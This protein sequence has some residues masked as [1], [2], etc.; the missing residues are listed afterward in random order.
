MHIY[1]ICFSVP[2][3]NQ[4]YIFPRYITVSMYPPPFLRLKAHHIIQHFNHII[5][6]QHKPFKLDGQILNIDVFD[7]NKQL[8]LARRYRQLHQE[9]Y[10]QMQLCLPHIMRHK[11]QKTMS[12]SS[13]K[14]QINTLRLL[15][16]YN[17]LDLPL[18]PS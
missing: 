6:L 18:D 10:I 12:R 9:L 7:G 3:C 16:F 1:H 15:S 2:H 11:Q 4:S 5:L 17:A 14:K 13:L 8:H